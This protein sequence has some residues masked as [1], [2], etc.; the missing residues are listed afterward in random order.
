M[1]KK[2]LKALRVVLT[3][4][5][6]LGLTFCLQAVL[7]PKY[8]SA[9]PEGS[10]IAEYYDEEKDFD[11]V[12]IGDCEVYE[13]FIPAVLWEE[14][15]INSYI[16]GS[17]QQLIWQSYYLMEETLSYEK[18]DV[19]VFNIMSMKY[20]EP[21]REEYN[22]M[23]LDGMRWS[24]YKIQSIK[25]SMTEEESFVDYIFPILRFHD[26]YKELTLEDLTAAFGHE[27]VTHNGYLMQ[28]GVRGITKE[29]YPTGR[30]L[31]DYTFGD[32][33]YDYLDRMVS[34]C[35][36]A[37]VQLVF[38]KAPSLSP[39]W[40]DEY[41]AQIDAYAAEH[42]IPY[43]NYLE[44]IEEVGIDFETD[45]YDMGLHLNLDGAT[46]LSGHF[47]AFLS[48]ELQ[49]PDRR[50]EE[51]LSAVWEEK[52]EAFYSEIEEKAAA[53]GSGKE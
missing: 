2:I 50:G 4:V 41:E 34:L 7:M 45:T 9:Q 16:R 13:N 23:S 3:I 18:P 52:L 1:K 26:R 8:L 33:A 53:E 10:M 17:A 19:I 32:N 5:I 42:D 21:Q 22:R 28:T 46:K 36:D 6:I 40:Y 20:N 27:K 48:E 43:I 30:V 47:G 25:A 14:Y 31:A 51:H 39:Y 29:N 15:G 24:R 44:L 38:V 11:V 37:G 12:F 35:E 49:V